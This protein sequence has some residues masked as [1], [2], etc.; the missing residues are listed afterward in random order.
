MLLPKTGIS[1]VTGAGFGFDAKSD[2]LNLVENTDY[3]KVDEVGLVFEVA[4]INKLN[5]ITAYL[6]GGSAIS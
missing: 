1:G 5:A 3:K 2:T 4:G 6:R